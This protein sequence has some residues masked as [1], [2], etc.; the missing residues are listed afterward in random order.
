ML[1][2]WGHRVIEDNF[3]LKYSMYARIAN[4]DN[5]NYTATP[6]GLVISFPSLSQHGTLAPDANFST[7][8]AVLHLSANWLP[9]CQNS[10]IKSGKSEGILFA[11]L[12]SYACAS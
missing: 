10:G 1:H 3:P 6:S 4:H 9:I 5:N 11:S 2:A 7:L 8:S 12:R